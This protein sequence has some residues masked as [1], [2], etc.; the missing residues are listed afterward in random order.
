[1]TC[2][3]VCVLFAEV[4]LRDIGLSRMSLRMFLLRN[5]GAPPRRLCNSVALEYQLPPPVWMGC[6]IRILL[7]ASSGTMRCG[8]MTLGENGTFMF[9]PVDPRS[10]MIR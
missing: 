8:S 6:V 2:S 10:E 1:M 4:N 9:V 5:G 7:D 3:R